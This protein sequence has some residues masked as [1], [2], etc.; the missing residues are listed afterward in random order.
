MNKTNNLII[1]LF[2]GILLNGCASTGGTIGGLIPAPK[3]IKGKI[4]DGIYTSP[5]SKFRISVPNWDDKSEYQYM[6]MKEQLSTTGIYLSFGPAAFK[7]NIYRVE[8]AEKLSSMS[9]Y[10][11]LK[12]IK[13]E[14]FSKYIKQIEKAYNSKV[15][16]IAEDI[17]LFDSKKSYSRI[18]R[19][20]IPRRETFFK[21]TAESLR[22]HFV[23]LIDY[24]S[25]SVMYWV[26]IPV[27]LDNK[28]TIEEK[29][30][31]R[32]NEDYY[33]FVNSF[34]YQKK[35]NKD[36][37][38]SI[39]E[40][41]YYSIGGEFSVKL[42]H[43]PSR[44]QEDSIE[45]DYTI[46]DESESQK[47]DFVIF[48]PSKN[49]YNRYHAVLLDFPLGRG[50]DKDEYVNR[51]LKKRLPG[52]SIGLTQKH[53]EKFFYKGLTRY[54]A[55]YESENDYFVTCI[56]DSGEK[57]FEIEADIYKNTKFP[58]VDLNQLINRDFE[59]FNR[60]LDSFQI[61]SK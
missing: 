54:Y 10:I 26:E 6:K 34:V 52:R 49:D 2:F 14:I 37:K 46:I 38:G 50:K 47:V 25:Y 3:I 43:P 7:N 51:I 33:N 58:K 60:M 8:Y 22:Y 4:K 18:Y 41:T 12:T 13:N 42:P 24:G 44:Y 53:F 11:E 17:D 21:T 56:T 45:W 59:V 9:Y 19:Q 39:K 29:L 1:L 48:G 20:S 5:K 15:E 32:D 27:N 61:L 36:I 31:N 30:K 55:V 23:D 16:L 35:P 57:F 40:D 28:K